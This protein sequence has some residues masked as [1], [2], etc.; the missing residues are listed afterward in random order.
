[1]NARIEKWDTKTIACGNC[2]AMGI[3]IEEDGKKKV[4]FI[5]AKGTVF[6]Y[7]TASQW[8]VEG[9]FNCPYCGKHNELPTE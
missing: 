9:G 8:V 5:R 6:G 1:M 3:P 2:G 7:C 4:L